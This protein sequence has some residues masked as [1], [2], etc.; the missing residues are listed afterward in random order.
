MNG[1]E[2]LKQSLVG[3]MA[4]IAE[5]KIQDANYDVC[6][7]AVVTAVLGDGKYQISRSGHTFNAVSR[8][9]DIAV[10]DVVYAINIENNNKT[11]IIIG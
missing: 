5:K 2:T 9:K 11:F 1:M 3:S 4:E 7:K 10:G 8:F 6:K